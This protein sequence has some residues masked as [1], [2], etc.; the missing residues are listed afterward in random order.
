[1]KTSQHSLE[2][3]R[4][5]AEALLESRIGALFRDLPPLCGFAVARDLSLFDVA[6]VTWPGY[7]VGAELYDEIAHAIT[8]I[9]DEGPEA[10][11]LLRGRTFARALH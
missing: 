4:R 5:R 7:G 9:L 3:S 2:T 8:D 10:T 6:T 11:E 1:M